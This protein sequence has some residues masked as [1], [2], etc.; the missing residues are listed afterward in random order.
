MLLNKRKTYQ[1]LTDENLI[2]SYKEKESSL[3]IGELYNRYAHL[4][5]G[6]SMK[7]LKNK[8]D[9]E[10]ITMIVFEKLA[11]R[12]TKSEI[13]NFKSW[14]YTV[15][16]NEVFMLFRKK[17]I[18]KT[19]LTNESENHHSKNEEALN[20]VIIKDQQLNQLESFV[21]TLNQ[22]QKDCIQLFYIERKSYQEISKILNMEIKKI[23]SAIQNGKRNLKIKLESCE[24]FKSI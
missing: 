12:I 6:V 22:D 5:F 8:H 20:A 19:E 3:I 14:L 11:S 13:K 4:V 16:K 17:G 24:E 18:S 23:K 1:K 15:T 21:E 7:Y 2:L 10:D 9:A